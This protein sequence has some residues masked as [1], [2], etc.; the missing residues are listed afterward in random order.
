MSMQ[1][2]ALRIGLLMLAIVAI[3][4]SQSQKAHADRGETRCCDGTIVNPDYDPSS[5]C[6]N[7]GGYQEGECFSS[8]ERC[9]YNY[10]LDRQFCEFK[11]YYDNLTDEE[12]RSCIDW[13][14]SELEKCF[15]TWP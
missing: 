8:Y 7:H 11:R 2:T 10:F 9:R 15:S 5:A 12:Y 4:F 14:I 13:A 6:S 1:I 3:G